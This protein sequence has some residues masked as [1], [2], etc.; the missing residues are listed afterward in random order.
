MQC[1]GCEGG[2]KAHCLNSPTARLQPAKAACTTR[3]NGH[4]D[5][6]SFKLIT[7]RGRTC[8][9]A[10]SVSL[11]KLCRPRLG[12]SYIRVIKTTI[13]EPA[14]TNH[15][16]RE[17]QLRWRRDVLHSKLAANSGLVLKASNCCEHSSESCLQTL[18]SIVTEV[19]AAGYGQIYQRA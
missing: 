12:K 2:Q 4:D 9:N 8:Q 17:S 16:S 11:A 18:Q 10:L 1:A 3:T 14:N 7:F 15:Y 6:N 5:C 19:E 13:E